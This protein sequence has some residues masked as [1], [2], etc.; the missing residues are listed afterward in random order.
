MSCFDATAAPLRA[1]VKEGDLATDGSRLTEIEGLSS[2]RGRVAFDARTEA[3]VR[4]PSDG[5]GGARESGR[6]AA[7]TACV[8][9]GDSRGSRHRRRRYGGVLGGDRFARSE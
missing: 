8:T 9:L 6:P 5:A 1:L 3:I 7:R 2:V 4:I